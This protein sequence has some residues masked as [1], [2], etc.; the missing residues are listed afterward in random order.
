MFH[1]VIFPVDISYSSSGGPGYRTIVYDGDGGNSQ[2]S[3]RWDTAR[4]QYQVSYADKNLAQA[5]TL[6]DFFMCRE[7]SKNTFRFKDFLDYS[8]ASDHR[9]APSATD[10]Q[11]GVGDGSTKTFQLL[12]QY[13]SS[14]GNAYRTLTKPDG[15]SVVVSLDDVTQASGWSVNDTT[16]VITFTTA[17]GA[18]VVVKAG[19]LFYVHVQFTEETDRL[20]QQSYDNFAQVSVVGDISLVERLPDDV[21]QTHDFPYGGASTITMGADI[22]ISAGLGRV[23]ELQASSGLTAYLE[24]VGKYSPGGPH[25]YLLNTGANAITIDLGGST[26]SLASGASAIVLVKKQSSTKSWVLLSLS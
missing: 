14:T 12:S 16:G 26:V 21:L 20:L 18:G 19:C 25:F 1:D 22:G 9:A 8:T 15:S 11:I 6:L 2:V 24:S 13:V 7:G 3:S 5:S 4:R 10:V 17:P 23:I